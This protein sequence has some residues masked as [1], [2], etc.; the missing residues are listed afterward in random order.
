MWEA[1]TGC[2]VAE[3]KGHG[4]IV[5]SATYSPDGKCIV[6][7]SYDNTA[8]VWEAETGCQVAE[9]KGH[10]DIVWSATYSPDG[11]R[12]VTASADKTARVWNMSVETQTADQIA[13]LI[14]CKVGARFDREDSNLIIPSLPNP[15]ECLPSP[16]PPR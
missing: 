9:L 7:A 8:R 14:R 12:I 16:Q 5:S 2:Q 1:E 4:A 11:K 15:A 3:L 10:G 13:K 6:T